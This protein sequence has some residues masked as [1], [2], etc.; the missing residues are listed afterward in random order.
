GDGTF[1]PPG[2]SDATPLDNPLVVD[3]KGDGTKDVL[4]VDGAGDI[5]YRQGIPGQPGSF[6]PPTIVNP[7]FPSR[8]IAWLPRTDR[9]PVLASV[10][11]RD[12]AISFYA[13]HDGQFVR[14]IGSISTGRLPA[15][16]IAA[17]LNGDGLSDLVVR[18]AGDGSL[19]VY[20]AT[21]APASPFV[22]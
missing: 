19:S 9:G 6:Q 20:L 16:F 4:V 17:Q 3:V 13:Y 7:G 21:F 2:R 8:D 11:A 10:D 18:N 1:S 22:G 12:N 14:L 15:Q 5:L